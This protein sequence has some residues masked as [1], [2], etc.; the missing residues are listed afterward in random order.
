[1]FELVVDLLIRHAVASVA[2]SCE[3]SVLPHAVRAAVQQVVLL[4]AGHFKDRQRRQR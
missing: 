4:V 3:L 1:M 2:K